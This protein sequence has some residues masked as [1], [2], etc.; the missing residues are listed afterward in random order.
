MGEPNVRW[1]SIPGRIGKRA[2]ALVG[3]LALVSTAFVASAAPAVA[4][5]TSCSPAWHTIKA[6]A[7]NRMVTF[8]NDYFFAMA[9]GSKGVAPWNQQ[10]LFCR[11][12]NW[13]AGHYGIYTN[14]SGL[15]CG[16]N[17]PHGDRE[18][19][20]CGW[21]RIYNENNL[22][23]IKRYDSK[24]WSIKHVLTLGC[25]TAH[26]YLDPL[27]ILRQGPCPQNGY[28]LFEIDG[29]PPDKEPHP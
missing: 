8:N 11:D 5:T 24:F 15:Y 4:S 22:F 10:V 7:L 25:V 21:G 9:N 14:Y 19:V 28:Q 2:A 18:F 13:T 1:I 23:E 27:E 29:T 6:S 16:R 3:L 17:E 12:P 26:S 20:S